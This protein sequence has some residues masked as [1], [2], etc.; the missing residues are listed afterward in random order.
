MSLAIRQAAKK[1]A[2][3]RHHDAIQKVIDEQYL[4]QLSALGQVPSHPRE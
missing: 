2:A 3:P 4:T 1:L